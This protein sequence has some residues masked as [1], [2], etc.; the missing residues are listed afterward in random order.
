MTNVPTRSRTAREGVHTKV[1]F[2]RRDAIEGAKFEAT[3]RD[4]LRPCGLM[5]VLATHY[6][7]E[8]AIVQEFMHL[9]TGV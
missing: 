8:M 9:A 7:A 4:V 6:E 3:D 2:S 1:E 5:P